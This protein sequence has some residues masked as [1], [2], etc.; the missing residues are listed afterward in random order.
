MIEEE[1]VVR[2]VYHIIYGVM[3]NVVINLSYEMQ[4]TRTTGVFQMMDRVA[5]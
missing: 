2:E 5:P 3:D 1:V 4:A